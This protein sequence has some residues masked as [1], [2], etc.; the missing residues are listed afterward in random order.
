M[1][2]TVNSKKA[3]IA[4]SFQICLQVKACGE[5]SP[6]VYL[7]SGTTLLFPQTLF[8]CLVVRSMKHFRPK[9]DPILYRS[10][11]RILYL[12]VFWLVLT[13]FQ[14]GT[15]LE[16]EHEYQT[17]QLTATTSNEEGRDELQE[18]FHNILLFC[19]RTTSRMER[20]CLEACRDSAHDALR[21][22]TE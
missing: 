9:E 21:V 22:Q 2:G 17:T 13:Y 8:W 18:A 11:A 20:Q 6:P 16:V 4:C 19:R 3:Y 15:K 12:D 5:R 1:L 7:F 14:H 10:S